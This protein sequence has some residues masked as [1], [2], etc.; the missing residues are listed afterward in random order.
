MVAQ[1]SGSGQLFSAMVPSRKSQR[2]WG[3]LAIGLKIGTNEVHGGPEK[4]LKFP[5]GE[6]IQLRFGQ[7]NVMK[8]NEIHDFSWIPTADSGDFRYDNGTEYYQKYQK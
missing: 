4:I 6:G 8:S 5:E 1:V 7:G 2:N 3:G